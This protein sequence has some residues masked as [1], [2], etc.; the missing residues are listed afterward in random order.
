M[1]DGR[2]KLHIISDTDGQYDRIFFVLLFPDG[3]NGWN[4]TIK[5][6]DEKT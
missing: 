3:G 1:A 4:S 5:C 2:P 6:V